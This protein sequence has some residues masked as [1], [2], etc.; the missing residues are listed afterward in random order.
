ML[1]SA[2]RNLRDYFLGEL[3]YLRSRAADF[4]HDYPKIAAELELS[5]GKSSD[6]HIEA[7]LQSVAYLTGHIQY[8]LDKEA[9]EISNTLLGILYPH[10]EKPFPSMAIAKIAVKPNGANF[11]GG[12]T[13]EKHRIAHIEAIGSA[14]SRPVCKFRTCFDTPLW[15]LEVAF[16]G[17]QPTNQY[18]FLSENRKV[19]SVL[20]LQICNTGNESI[21]SYPLNMLRF[22]INGDDHQA[23]S[24]Y[25]L[26]REHLHGIVLLPDEQTNS[27]SIPRTALEFLGFSDAHAMLPYTQ[28]SHPAYR[29]LQEYFCFPEKH[30]FFEVTQLERIEKNQSFDILFLF[31]T[32]IP[33]QLKI[34]A[35]NFL[36]NCVPL[37]NIFPLYIDPLRLDHRE[38]EYRIIPSQE[39]YRYCEIYSIDE[40]TATKPSGKP[41]KLKSYFGLNP[42]EEGLEDHFY[43]TSRRE[44]SHL[45]SLCGT[46]MYVS[47]H[48]KFFDI[49]K[50]VEESIA[51][52]VSCTNRNLPE[53]MRAGDRLHLE[54]V[55]P[56]T[57]ME[58]ITKPTRHEVPSLNGMKPW[59]LVSHLCLNYLSLSSDPQSLLALKAILML[60]ANPSSPINKR[61]IDSLCHMQ[62]RQIVRRINHD[63]WR[64]FCRGTEIRLTLDESLFEGGSSLLFGEVLNRFFAL[65]TSINAFTQLV[66]E[67]K[68]K[69]G[70]WRT[71]QPMVGEQAI[72]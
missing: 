49:H 67:S 36:L 40:M 10:L 47:F 26:L 9:P 50:P 60:Y 68:Q 45:K 59:R 27:V 42:K 6:P 37:I 39:Q 52:H 23:F 58:L 51:A 31:E 64:G 63:A 54:G 30:L 72:L 57:H 22:Y 32:P 8:Q 11:T 2:E 4:S 46:E 34:Q 66:L 62:C 70:I 15:P 44:I 13:L 33:K 56:V 18:D 35:S 1:Q 71:W 53:K 5:R 14:G 48:D 43:W 69:K 28:A 41:R 29:I 25:R 20:R 7:L 24:L 61:Q 21:H 55:G 12:Y 17:E 19:L 3:D 65:Y 16:A 38:F